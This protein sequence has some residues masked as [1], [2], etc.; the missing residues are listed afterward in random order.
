VSQVTLSDGTKV[1]QHYDFNDHFEPLAVHNQGQNPICWYETRATMIE[2]FSRM[3]DGKALHLDPAQIGHTDDGWAVSHWSDSRTDPARELGT[4]TYVGGDHLDNLPEYR[5]LPLHEAIAKALWTNG[6]LEGGVKC[7][8]SFGRLWAKPWTYDGY[9][10]HKQRM[11]HLP[12]LHTLPGDLR[13]IKTN[14]WA[15]A[16]IYVGYRLVEDGI[17]ILVQNSWGAKFFGKAGRCYIGL[18]LVKAGAADAGF[19]HSWNDHPANG[20]K[21]PPVRAA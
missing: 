9:N 21:M 8:Q 15:H 19:I 20:L 12:V 1:P 17:E 3:Y 13:A 6:V 5:D 7:A 16:V 11:T 18:D 4:M 10:D 14:N 2:A